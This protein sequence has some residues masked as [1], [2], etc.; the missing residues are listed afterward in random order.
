[1]TGLDRYLAIEAVRVTE[2]AA[3]AA[4]EQ[5][6]QGDERAADQAAVDAMRTALNEIDI[7]GTVVIGEGERDEAPMLYIG[8][9][10]GRGGS[11]VDVAL[12]PLEG[13]TITAKGG[14]Q[15]ARGSRARRR[16]LL[17]QLARC[18]YGGRSRSAAACPRGIVDLDTPP[19]DGGRQPGRG[20]APGARRHCRLHPRSAAARRSHRR[21]A[22]GRRADS[23]DPRRRHRRGDRDLD[24]GNRD[25]RLYG[26]RRGRPKGSSPR[27]PCSASAGRCRGG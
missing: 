24:A 12:D 10:V 2:A 7:D 9:K 8:E 13:T 26:H 4:F 1:M 19:R 11:K 3:L 15:R 17:P 18:L 21:G 14:P 25:R 6:G 20:A 22:Q 27:P 5:M 23:P 16:G